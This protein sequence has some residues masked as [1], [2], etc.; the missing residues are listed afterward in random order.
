MCELRGP[1]AAVAPAVA[2]TAGLIG[3]LELLLGIPL[4]DAMAD[5]P[6]DPEVSGAVLR[7][8]GSL[9][10]VLSEVLAYESQESQRLVTVSDARAAYVSS[11]AWTR[12]ILARAS[13]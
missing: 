8:E 5:L 6:L 1:R 9:G 2:F 4:A 7:H 3:S 11:M 12:S 10:S 13:G